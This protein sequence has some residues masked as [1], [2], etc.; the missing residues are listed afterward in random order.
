MENGFSL[1]FVKVW[2]VWSKNSSTSPANPLR[3]LCTLFLQQNMP[4]A[5]GAVTMD[6]S[7]LTGGQNPMV[8]ATTG[9]GS[10]VSTQ[11]MLSTQNPNQG[12][13]SGLLSLPVIIVIMYIYHALINA[14]SAH[15]IH[16]N[17]NTVFYTYTHRAQSYQNSQASDLIS[18]FYGKRCKWSFLS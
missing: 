13:V 14:L 8:T 18:M 4:Q 2:E 9:P 7:V 10:A 5:Q 16:I 12:P 17:L 1:S 3:A 11:P 6:T 15:M